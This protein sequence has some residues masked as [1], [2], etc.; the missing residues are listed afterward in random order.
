[1][2]VMCQARDC[3]KQDSLALFTTIIKM[4]VNG[5]FLHETQEKYIQVFRM[6]ML[7]QPEVCVR[8][9]SVVY[10]TALLPGED[11]GYQRPVNSQRVYHESKERQRG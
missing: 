6:K 8:N 4:T 7:L 10:F 9:Q 2:G 3:S 1:M 5:V 11:N